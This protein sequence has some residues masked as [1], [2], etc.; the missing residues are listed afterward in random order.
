MH[1]CWVNCA[2]R[3]KNN[4]HTSSYVHRNISRVDF[5]DKC[6][7]D[8]KK[9]K[10]GSHNNATLENTSVRGKKRLLSFLRSAVIQNLK[11]NPPYLFLF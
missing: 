7:S 10:N 1:S 5:K 9:E 6:K 11:Q 2:T 3:F 8:A 4:A